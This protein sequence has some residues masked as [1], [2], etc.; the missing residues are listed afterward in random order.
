MPF[1]TRAVW[2]GDHR[3]EIVAGALV[4][5]VVVV[6]GYASGIGGTPA[7]A[8]A[9]VTPPAPPATSAPPSPGPPEDSPTPPAEPPAAPV[10]PDP[11]GGDPVALPPAV[12]LPVD[13]GGGNP[14]NGGGTDHHAGNGHTEPPG[15]TPSPSPSAPDD[16][17]QGDD[18]P[19]NDGSVHLFEPLLK[20]VS[21][22]VFGVLDLLSGQGAEAPATSP[23]APS[24]PS[25]GKPAE[26]SAE[27]PA[28][29]PA[30]P[31]GGCRVPAPSATSSSS[32]PGTS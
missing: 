30:D 24:G 19:C 20:H 13:D 7:D 14:G 15:S 27:K 2:P 25:A 23:A 4:G 11:G 26:K 31:L 28:D 12:T 5:A 6:L 3:D 18:E 10:A 16:G 21:A 9:T 8:Q 29:Q 22:P 32:S 1:F 17:R